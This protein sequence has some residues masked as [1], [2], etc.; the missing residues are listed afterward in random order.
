MQITIIGI[1]QLGKVLAL[2]LLRHSNEDLELVFKNNKALN[3]F[4]AAYTDLRAYKYHIVSDNIALELND[5]IIIPCLK[6]KQANN[7][8]TQGK[9]KITMSPVVG[10]DFEDLQKFYPANH[11]MQFMPNIHALNGDSVSTCLAEKSFD[12]KADVEQILSYFGDFTWVKDKASYN[13][14]SILTSCTSAFLALSCEALEDAAVGIGIPKYQAR[15][16][17]KQIFSGFSKH[18]ETDTANHIK[19]AISSPAGLCTTGVKA[20]EAHKIRHGFMQSYEASL[21]R[22][23]ELQKPKDQTI[24]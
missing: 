10:L 24:K 19:E 13:S 4:Q 11:Y 2:R 17:L 1:G 6:F 3:E 9:A 20:L 21:A 18:L 7:I 22:L 23:E 5:K 14:Y 8:T 16:L 12:A 15:P